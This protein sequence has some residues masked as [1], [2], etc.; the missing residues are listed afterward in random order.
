MGKKTLKIS[1][2]IFTLYFLVSTFLYGCASFK[3]KFVRKPKGKKRPTPIIYTKDYTQQY[4]NI[5][6]YKKHYLFWRY[7]QEELINSLGLNRKKEIRCA[8]SALDELK[9]LNNYLNPEGK[10]N[11]APYI[12]KLEDI[13]KRIL[14]RRPVGLQI[15]KLKRELEKHKRA[16]ERSFF[17]KDVEEWII[18]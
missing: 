1:L 12:L 4:P 16:V 13:T 2:L 11:L 9:T 7:W 15:S 6:L 3:K 10:D 18:E 17:Y 5:L 14:S 8:R